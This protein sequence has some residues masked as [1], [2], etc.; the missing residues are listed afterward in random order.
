MASAFSLSDVPEG[1]RPTAAGRGVRQPGWSVDETGTEEPFLVLGPASGR[2][3]RQDLVLISLTGFHGY[4]GGFEQALGCCGVD[5]RRQDFEVDGRRA[6]YS[7]PPSPGFTEL[8]VDRGD[9]VAVRIQAWDAPRQRLLDLLRR[10]T[11]PE[12]HVDPPVVDEPPDGLVVVGAV[13]GNLSLTARSA[14]PWTDT[15]AVTGFAADVLPVTTVGYAAVWQHPRASLSVAVVPKQAEPAGLIAFDMVSVVDEISLTDDGVELE[16]TAQ[17]S[18]TR[19]VVTESPWGDLLVVASAGTGR[20]EF[21][22][23]WAIAG[24]VTRTDAAGWERMEQQARGGPDLTADPGKVELLRG[25]EAGQ[26]WI[27]QALPRADGAGAF[28]LDPCIKLD[29]GRHSCMNG[30]VDVRGGAWGRDGRPVGESDPDGLPRFMLVR[31]NEEAVELIV[32]RG[33]EVLTSPM[34]RVP[35]P[36][37]QWGGIVFGID[38][39]DIP[40][41]DWSGPLGDYGHP[42][43]IEVRGSDGVLRCMAHG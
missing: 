42:M 6:A 13:D 24:S 23:L 27:V 36:V 8:L 14:A 5:G 30:W 3:E 40:R 20:L 12:R 4:Q 26:S 2:R 9:D 22:D 29:T 33:D 25:E 28:E 17:F 15:G 1:F 37:P 7:T 21:A 11:L 39:R 16:W 34:R 19:T 35:G 10:V 32:T 31:T 41:C 43:R 38:H 18:P